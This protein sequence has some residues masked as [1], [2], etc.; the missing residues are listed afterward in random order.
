MKNLFLGILFLFVS[1][2]AFA[3]DNDVYIMQIAAY[4]EKVSMKYFKTAGLENVK[5]QFSLS[6]F[7]RYYQDGFANKEEATQAMHE[8]VSKGFAFARVINISEMEDLCES[9]CKP[10]TPVASILVYSED[11][12]VRVRNIF[13]GFDSSKLNKEGRE[14]LEKLSE[15][16]KDNKSYIVEVHAHTDGKGSAEYN[17]KLS[18]RR[19]NAVINYLQYK[20]IPGFQIESYYHG[21]AQPLARN[22]ASGGDSPMGRKLN[23]R[24]D[25]KIKDQYKMLDLV[26]E[27]V[28]PQNLKKVD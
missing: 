2:I 18:E 26:E 8:A 11:Q 19:M 13:F 3:Q 4:G 28:V 23:R 1:G 16:L 9:S 6:T 12:I 7:Y 27:I 15:V 22:E 20:G 25:L 24:V 14:E 21:E 10:S 17:L 5:E